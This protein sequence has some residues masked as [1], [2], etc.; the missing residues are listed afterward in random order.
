MD[1]EIYIQIFQ[2][3]L[4]VLIIIIIILMIYS[5]SINK[6]YKNNE[7][8][9]ILIKQIFT[10]IILII[11]F[12]YFIILFIEN[13]QQE[14]LFKLLKY[15]FNIYII[16]LYEINYNIILDYDYSYT[17]PLHFFSYLL[18]IGKNIKNYYIIYFI[19]LIII[20]SLF[21]I[22]YCKT[23]LD[24]S[25]YDIIS[26]SYLFQ[27]NPYKNNNIFPF[28]LTNKY[29]GF[30]LIIISFLTIVEIIYLLYQIG[31]FSFNK[32]K[33]LKRNLVIYLIINLFYFAYSLTSICIYVKE[34]SQI[35]S[36][37][38]LSIIFVENLI[39]ILKYSISKFVQFKL[40][41]TF[42]G[43]IGFHINRCFN[44]KNE[45][46]PLTYSTDHIENISSLLLMNNS[47]NSNN[48]FNDILN[49]FDKEL[50]QMYKNDIYIEDY[51]LNFFDKI[52]NIITSSL[53]KLYNSEYFSTKLINNKR[54]SK[55][56]NLSVSS[57]TGGEL[58]DLS[59]NSLFSDDLNL[60]GNS[61]SFT[62]Y[63]NKIV[64]NYA[65]FQEVLDNDTLSEDIRVNIH[66]YYSN[67][68]MNN[69]L[70]KN[71]SSKNIANSLISHMLIRKLNNSSLSSSENQELPP[72]NYYSLT[73]ANGKESYFKNL[74][75]ICFKTFDKK[76]SLEI[77]E[78]NDEIN[79]LRINSS[80][81]NNNNITDLLNKYFNYLQNKG[82][83][84]TFLPIILG[85]FKIK[86]NYFNSLIV[87]IIDNS[88]VENVPMKYFTNWQLIRFK[89]KNLEKVA[90]SRYKRN[91][92]LDD[93]KI[94]K[95]LESKIKIVNFDEVKITISSDI[96]FLKTVGSY[97]FNLLLMYYQYD[98]SQKHEKY[99]SNGVIKIR[100]SID[101]KPEI[102]DDILPLGKLCDDNS[103]ISNG[104]DEESIKK[105]IKFLNKS[106][107]SKNN[108]KYSKNKSNKNNEN[109][110][111][112]VSEDISDD[113]F[114]I[115]GKEN[116][117]IINFS[118][119]INITGYNG[120]YDSY[121]CLCYFTFE[122]IFYINENIE[123]NY[124]FYKDYLNKILNHFSSL[125]E[126]DEEIKT[127]NN[128]KNIN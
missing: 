41:N 118:E 102:I 48:S 35:N 54:L 75:N 108:K 93:D 33:L 3:S 28:I 63:K 1:N 100:N 115:E 15:F 64:N 82:I 49:P 107:S 126:K 99:L 34:D 30:I 51:Y 83:N 111:Q 18:K 117:N 12:V 77:F 110:I 53:Y 17:Y 57:I 10:L 4:V 95:N 97:M 85:I 105:S 37:I 58:S 81:K 14:F 42:L 127:I 52:L 26:S 45:F 87:I 43:Y 70:E 92:I 68:C 72:C 13:K 56:M 73:V 88:I 94:F 79:D 86:I 69:I 19:C 50:I 76:Y 21:D 104:S 67:Q 65:L 66:S 23:Q 74:N 39:L 103:I 27:C 9:L 11:Y 90:S 60:K 101:N 2:F 29:R 36:F 119:Q 84:N 44:K 61:S 112:F 98:S 6:K 106:T 120:F 24:E 121:N 96:N 5:V 128:N 114:Q 16:F 62:F 116:E 113:S 122:N 89:E 80:N 32:I 123:N 46:L 55:E 7:D 31:K 78:T 25:S 109:E 40:R 20:T 59:S 124:E 22:L 38:I 91:T 125:N 71:Y 8:Y 47:Y